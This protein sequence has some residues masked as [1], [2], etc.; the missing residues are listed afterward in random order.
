M[1][2]QKGFTLVEM[3]IVLF[4]IAVLI[5]IIIPNVTKHF[6]TVDEKGCTA[7][8]KMI[9]GQVEAYKVE[10]GTYPSNLD[11]LKRAGY[12]KEGVNEKACGGKVIKIQ[13]GEVL[14][15]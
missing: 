14:N 6:S 11:D 3:L 1:K 8:V 5:I 12:L 7:Y 2:N 15:P 13:D 9:Q 10:L 4:I